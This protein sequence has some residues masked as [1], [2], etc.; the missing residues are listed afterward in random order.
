[1]PSANNDTL[2]SSL[3]VCN[4]LIPFSCL[5]ALAMTSCIKSNRSEE[6]DQSCL[7]PDFSE[8]SLSFP[9]FELVFAIGLYIAFIMFR[10]VPSLLNLSW[11]FVMKGV[12]LC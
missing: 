6:Y 9:P 3:P 11:T 10:Y 2:A 5:I 4:H 8:I 7:V 1:M 12:G